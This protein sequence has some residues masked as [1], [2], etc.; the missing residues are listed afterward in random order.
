VSSFT[1]ST[2]T[3]LPFGAFL[4]SFLDYFPFFLSPP[5]SIS[6]SPFNKLIANS[7]NF[8][9]LGYYSPSVTAGK[10]S[11]LFT[12]SALKCSGGSSI[13]YRLILA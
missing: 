5:V 13:S 2:S 8:S 3:F 12:K 10:D 4:S 1:T 7:N 11:W 9:I 6:I